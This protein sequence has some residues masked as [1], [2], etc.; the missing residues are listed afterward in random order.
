MLKRYLA[1][2]DADL[3]QMLVREDERQEHSLEM[4]A[5]ENF[6]SRSVL[7]AYTSTLTNK[8]AEGYPGKRYYNG[9]EQADEVESLAI[10]RACKLFGAKHAN[11][12][13]HSGAQANMAVF[14]GFLKPGDTFMGMDLNHGG[15]LSH[16]S[17]V[18]FSGRYF[19]VVSYGVR[20]EDHRIDYD[21]VQKLAREHKPKVII[22][23]FS[24]YSRELDFVKF[25]EI[26]DEIGA[27]VMADIAHIAGLVAT[28]EHPTSIDVAHITTTTTHKTLRGPRGGLILSNTEEHHKLMNSRVFPGTQGGPLMHVIAAKA[29]AFGEALRPEYRQYARQ[30]KANAR[31]LAE[32]FLKRGFRVVSGGTDNHLVLLDVSG[33]NLTGAVA[34][35][36]LHEA[37]ITANKN[38]IPFDTQPP[39]ISSGVRFGSPALTTR[40]FGQVEFEAVGNLICD[41]LEKIDDESALKRVRAGVAELAGKYPMDRF[42]LD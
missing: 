12:Q 26:A 9:C 10:E 6:V 5:S 25:R 34:A 23:G 15:H 1:D 37:G 14:L 32:V 29:A 18:N 20:A 27:I 41:L 16:G 38:A 36:R 2:S 13:P 19:N 31:T 3:Y 17:K 40:G 22:A 7:E 24:A 30:V 11:V 35:D 8:Y 21:N 42:R 4:I 33:R 39:A 28:G